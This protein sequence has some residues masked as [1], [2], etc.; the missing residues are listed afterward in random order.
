MVEAFNDGL[1]QSLQSLRVNLTGSTIIFARADRVL[2]KVLSDPP[3][4]GFSK[5]LDACCG[6]GTFNGVGPC[7]ILNYTACAQV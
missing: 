4:S 6:S 2:L 7:G 3:A 1:A 5:S